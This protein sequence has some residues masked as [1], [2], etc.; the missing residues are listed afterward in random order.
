MKRNSYRTRKKENCLFLYQKGYYEMKTPVENKYSA[1]QSQPHVR[2]YV[3]NTL[4]L[5]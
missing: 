1:T 5:H 3:A 2:G 4:R